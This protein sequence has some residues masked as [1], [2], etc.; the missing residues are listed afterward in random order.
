VRAK[1]Q[2]AVAAKRR[3]LLWSEKIAVQVRAD[4]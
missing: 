1:K 3:T 4:L 2:C